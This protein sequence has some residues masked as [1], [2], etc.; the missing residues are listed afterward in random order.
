MSEYWIKK[1]CQH[2]E[3]VAYSSITIL[4]VFKY[5][6]IHVMHSVQKGISPGLEIHG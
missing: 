5:Q 4:N 1:L 2:V 3:C 6:H